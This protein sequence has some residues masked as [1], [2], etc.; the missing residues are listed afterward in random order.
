MSTP[1]GENWTFIWE[2]CTNII[3]LVLNAPKPHMFFQCLIMKYTNVSHIFQ[4]V[5][6]IENP[7]SHTTHDC[8]LIITLYRCACSGY[9]SL[10]VEPA[11]AAYKCCVQAAA[12]RAR[13][14]SHQKVQH[15]E[16]VT[17]AIDFKFHH[18]FEIIW[19]TL[20]QC[21]LNLFEMITPFN[22]KIYTQSGLDSGPK[23][24]YKTCQSLVM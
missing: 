6:N 7:W 21:I 8:N 22:Q 13:K 3:Y 16:L 19:N 18:D 9:G 2:Y 1:I 23:E 20:L 11:P 12:Y 24:N 15:G 10:V 5:N 14:N 4:N 17:P